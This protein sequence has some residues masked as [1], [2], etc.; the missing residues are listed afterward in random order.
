MHHPGVY[1]FVLAVTLVLAVPIVLMGY[2]LL[3][4]QPR[5]LIPLLR[6][7]TGEQTTSLIT[8]ARRSEARSCLHCTAAI[9]H[10]SEFSGATF[11]YPQEAR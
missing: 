5:V 9:T 1:L 8:S 6:V 3:A 10:T 11:T 7:Q 2:T 4:M